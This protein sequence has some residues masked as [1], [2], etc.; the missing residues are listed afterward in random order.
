VEPTQE[1]FRILEHPADIG[2]EA[3]GRTLSDAFVMA[4]RGLTSVIVDP[5]S[6]HPCG[7]RHVA[8]KGTDR[9]NLLVLW[10]SE[11]VFLYDGGRF[12]ASGFEINHLT[13]HELEATVIGEVVD[14]EKHRFRTDV[15]AVT[16]H[17]L[18]VAEAL[19]GFVVRVFLDI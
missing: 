13:D 16:Y 17:Q 1:G 4:A 5:S 8:V 14:E 12:L 9:E 10:L 2:I 11:I 6:V 18:M 15:K 7:K 3:R 19:D